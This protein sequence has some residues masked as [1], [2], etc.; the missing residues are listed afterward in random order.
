MPP[1]YTQSYH[2]DGGNVAPSAT[3]CHTL[4]HLLLRAHVHGPIELTIGSI[5]FFDF[6]VT[7]SVAGPAKKYG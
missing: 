5:F 3:T 6:A 1:F 4:S 2:W 7:V